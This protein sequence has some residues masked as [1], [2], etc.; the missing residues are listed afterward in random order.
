MKARRSPVPL[1]SMI[2][3]ERKEER[4]MHISW[5][6]LSIDEADQE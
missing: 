5:T 1:P 3:L 2:L 6:P 4:K